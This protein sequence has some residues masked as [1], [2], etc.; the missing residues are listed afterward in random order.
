MGAWGGVVGNHPEV[1]PG[2]KLVRELLMSR[3]WVLV[4]SLGEGEVVHGGPFTR[5]DPATGNKSCLDLCMVSAGLRP[6][7]TSM[8]I[9]SARVM[10]PRV[11]LRK[12]RK[13]T[14]YSDHYSCLVNLSSLPRRKEGKVEEKVHRW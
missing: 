7:V 10:T 1:S 2:G 8:V 5:E 13:V 3:E 14:T 12:G 11:V 4:N 6:Y 9:D